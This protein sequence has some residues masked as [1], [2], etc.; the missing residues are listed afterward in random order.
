MKKTT[1]L[2]IALAFY[3]MPNNLFAQD[4]NRVHYIIYKIVTKQKGG[5]S[6][7]SY[8]T[9]MLPA[10]YSD[11]GLKKLKAVRKKRWS[12]STT[13]IRTIKRK[14]KPLDRVVLIKYNYKNGSRKYSRIHLKKF[15]KKSKDY[16]IS[17]SDIVAKENKSSMIREYYINNEVLYDGTP[18]TNSAKERKIM[19]E[20]VKKAE[21]LGVRG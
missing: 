21:G 19:K 1:I 20:D 4:E 14:L 12:N 7:D 17:P 3:I 10:T 6:E 8:R 2:L 15:S 11:S 16:K 9:D 13:T 18:F 5:N